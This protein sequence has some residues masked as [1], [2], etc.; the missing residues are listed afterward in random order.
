[1]GNCSSLTQQTIQCSKQHILQR[2]RKELQAAAVYDKAAV[3]SV[4]YMV[5]HTIW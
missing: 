4:L 1:M 3:L 5:G 2:C